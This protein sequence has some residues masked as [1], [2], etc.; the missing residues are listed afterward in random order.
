MAAAVSHRIHA[1]PDGERD[2]EH[3]REDHVA[4]VL[5]CLGLKTALCAEASI[6]DNHVDSTEAP[7][8]R[9]DQRPLRLPVGD[10][11]RERQGYVGATEPRHELV[12]SLDAT[13]GEHE[14]VARLGSHARCR[15][16]DSAR[17]ARDHHDAVRH[18]I[19]LALPSLGPGSDQPPAH[20]L[21]IHRLRRP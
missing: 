1:C 20:R 16:A 18:A 3:V 11:A 19:V 12:E 2:P 10:I 14:R 6:R 9:V 21:D 8:R 5:G 17:G 4:P 7:L 15:R 13:R